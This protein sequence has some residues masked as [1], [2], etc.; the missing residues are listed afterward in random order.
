MGRE[1]IRLLGVQLSGL[2]SGSSVQ[3]SMFDEKTDTRNE[4]LDKTLDSIRK[5]YGDNVIMRSV[6]LE[7]EEK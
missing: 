1:P 5:K 4:I 7:K 2:C 6:L 3:I